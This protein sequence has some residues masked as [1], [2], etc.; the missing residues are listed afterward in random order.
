MENSAFSMNEIHEKKYTYYLF[1]IKLFNLDLD[2][3]KSL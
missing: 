3:H 2:Q 1:I